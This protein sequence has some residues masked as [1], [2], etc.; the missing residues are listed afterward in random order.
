VLTAI[1]VLGAFSDSILKPSGVIPLHAAAFGKLRNLADFFKQ[2]QHTVSR[3]DVL[4]KLLEDHHV[5]FLGL[6]PACAK[7]KLHY[8]R[9]IPQKWRRFGRNLTCFSTERRH[10]FSKR[11]ASYTYN[12]LSQ[13]MLAH[14]VN[15]FFKNITCP[16]TFEA[17]RLRGTLKPLSGLDGMFAGMGVFSKCVSAVM[18]STTRGTFYKGD[19]LL[20]QKHAQW[21]VG[22]A[23]LFL[24]SEFV[25]GQPLHF[26]YVAKLDYLGGPCWSQSSP[27]PMLLCS[28]A[29]RSAVPFQVE[30]TTVRVFMQ[31]VL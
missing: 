26:A 28:E 6:Y 21:H 22:V 7:P 10:R 31:T 15:E 9:H 30:G 13:S 19:L 16:S 14:D 20:W 1:V 18:L 3:V 29:V 23:Q 8:A 12:K 2:G 5:F 24:R 25:G 17:T 4:E 11:I 27:A